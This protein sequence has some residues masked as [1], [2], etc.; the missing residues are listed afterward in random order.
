MA[1]A[2][3]LVPFNAPGQRKD[4]WDA[5]HDIFYS[6]ISARR[7]HYS[8]NMGATFPDGTTQTLKG[9]VF[10]NADAHELYNDNQL[11]TI[12]FTGKWTYKADHGE[13]VVYIMDNEKHMSKN[14]LAD[15]QK[16]VFEKSAIA[17]YLDSMVLK[18]SKV[19]SFRNSNDT[20]TAELVFPPD[21]MV[22]SMSLVYDR[23]HKKL[24]SYSVRTFAPWRGIG[25][26][27]NSGTSNYI[28]C[29]GFGEGDDKVFSTGN[30]FIVSNNKVALKKYNGYKLSSK[31]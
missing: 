7:M 16:G 28:T 4:G 21:F 5:V 22:R 13:K 20:I 8:Y 17:E 11:Q 14:H 18:K 23:A 9:E 12:I 10:V 1:T 25:A 3:A 2:A 15:M 6:V 27:K 24:I 19:K 31:L 30:Y 29:S 26:K